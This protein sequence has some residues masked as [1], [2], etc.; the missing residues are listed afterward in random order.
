MV[1]RQVRLYAL[2]H[3]YIEQMDEKPEDSHKKMMQGLILIDFYVLP[4]YL[5]APFKESYRENND[6]FRI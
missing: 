3:Q 2:K 4:H 1:N 6:F 5:T